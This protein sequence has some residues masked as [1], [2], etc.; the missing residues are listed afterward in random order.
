M[1]DQAQVQANDAA[2]DDMADEGRGTDTV[3]AH[4]TV[5]EIVIPLPLAQNER[6]VEHLTMYF[7]LIGG[8]I[9]EF[10]VGNAKNKINPE[11]GHPE[12]GFFSSVWNAVT[13]PV[14]TVAKVIEGGVKTGIETIKATAKG[15]IGGAIEATV[16]GTGQT[17]KDAYKGT[18]K[19]VANLMDV[20]GILPKVPQVNSPSDS[21][22]STVTQGDQ[23]NQR[24]QAVTDVQAAAGG[25]ASSLTPR[26]V[27]GPDNDYKLNKSAVLGL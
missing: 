20:V 26:T 18:V 17:L 13:Q 21:S 6:F 12:F 24:Q 22:P 15:D 2:M 8:D 11:T 10:T 3:M 9:E 25:G 23:Q 5:G 14:K 27:A 4:L 7:E 19:Q 1:A 16:Q